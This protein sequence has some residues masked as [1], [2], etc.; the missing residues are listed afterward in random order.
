LPTAPSEE[1][2]QLGSIL[3]IRISRKR[4][5]HKLVRHLGLLYKPGLKEERPVLGDSRLEKVF[6][7]LRDF[8]GS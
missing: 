1:I 8:I 5:R 7:L 4:D 3:Q 2:F 6:G